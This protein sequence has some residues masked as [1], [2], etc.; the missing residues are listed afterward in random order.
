MVSRR[1]FQKKIGLIA[2]LAAPAVFVRRAR[3]DDLVSPDSVSY[4]ATPSDGS[5]CSLC[6]N[7]IPGATS[8]AMGTCKVVAG[9]VS[10]MGYCLAFSPL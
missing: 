3:A 5:H 10:P 9:S 8:A 2:A 6:K 7:F 4:Q 1:N